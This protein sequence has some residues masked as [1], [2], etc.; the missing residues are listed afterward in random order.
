MMHLLPPLISHILGIGSVLFFLLGL[1]V[2]TLG[3]EIQQKHQFLKDP[4]L[5]CINGMPRGFVHVRGKTV[6]GASLV[7]PLTQLPCCYYRTTISRWDSA[8]A[9]K[10]R[11]IFDDTK[12]NEFQIHDGGGKI[13]VSSGG[14]EFDLPKAYS[15][16]ID[17]N[18]PGVSQSY[19]EPSLA[20]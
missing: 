4:P 1:Y 7:S 10:F 16:E 5:V 3:V 13:L 15:V 18:T 20:L 2:C 9:G 17:I 12:E 19:V 14:A 11:D 6:L 8:A